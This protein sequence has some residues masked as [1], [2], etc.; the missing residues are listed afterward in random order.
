[1]SPIVAAAL[2]A[3]MT[4]LGR[5]ARGKTLTI[6]TVVGLVGV[7]IGLTVLEQA[8]Q[9]FARGFAIL[10]VIGVA[11]AHLDV[12]VGSSGLSGGGARAGTGSKG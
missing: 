7:A 10:V 2:V 3:T 9:K 1:M 6:D 8:N 12:I 11:V 4:T 5:W